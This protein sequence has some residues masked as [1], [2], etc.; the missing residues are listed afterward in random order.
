[1]WTL[2]TQRKAQERAYE[3]LREQGM[4]TEDEID[5]MHRLFRLYNI[6]YI[7]DIALSFLEVLYYILQIVADK[8][9]RVSK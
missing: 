5:A 9:L 7:N 3:L 2:R 6:E 8:D 4:A 1:M